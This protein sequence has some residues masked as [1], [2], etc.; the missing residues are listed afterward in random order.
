MDMI[1]YFGIL[2]VQIAGLVGGIENKIAP[3]PVPLVGSLHYSD[4]AIMPML[5]IISRFHDPFVPKSVI[6]QLKLLEGGG[7]TFFAQ[8]VSP[9]YDNVHFPR[10]YTS[11]KGSG[12]SV[13]GIE[14]DNQLVGGAA[15]NPS[16]YVPASVM[17]RTP[18]GETAW[19]NHYPTSSVISA[20][21]T[22]NNLTVLYPPSRAFPGNATTSKTMSFLFSGHRHLTLHEDFLIG[23]SA[24]LPGLK[25]G[26]SGN[27]FGQNTTF[28]YITNSI[29]G[30]S[31]YNLTY[32][33]SENFTEVPSLTISFEKV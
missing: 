20:I 18:I 17:W 15:I 27:L 19:I 13:G 12:L 25:L 10:N 33:I 11:W 4:A 28:V 31:F 16:V 22:A 26:V 24:E 21:A 2:G 30:L 32:F 5:P 6:S 1:C 9:P 29:D 14:V 3:L 8:A 7:Q 23:G